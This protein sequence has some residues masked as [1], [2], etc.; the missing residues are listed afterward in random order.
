MFQ[1]KFNFLCLLPFA[2]AA[3]ACGSKN[4]DDT[5]L[6][7]TRSA[8]LLYLEALDEYEDR[9]CVA[10]EPNFQDV[11]RNFPYSRY[12]VLAELRLADCQFVQGNHAEAAVAYE[13][14]VKAHPTHEDAHYAAYKRGLFACPQKIRPALRLLPHLDDIHSGKNGLLHD[15][16]SRPSLSVFFACHKIKAGFRDI[17]HYSS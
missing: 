7:Y 8:E 5:L 3:W 15:L 17:L 12:A 16:Q 14:F 11:R 2:I 6:D 4:K 10:A 9:D 1:I 13:Q